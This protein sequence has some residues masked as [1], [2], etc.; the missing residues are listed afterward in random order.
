MEEP[1]EIILHGR[2]LCEQITSYKLLEDLSWSVS[3]K[4]WVLKFALSGDFQGTDR[5]PVETLWYALISKNY[6]YGSLCIFPATQGGII[7]TFPHMNIN[8]DTGKLWRSGDICI[9]TQ[10]GTW[11]STYFNK[12][13]FDAYRLQWCIKR[14][15]LWI[16]A[17]AERRLQVAGDPFEFPH[18]P[19]ESKI[20]T[21]WIFSED[22]EMFQ[23]WQVSGNKG[24]LEFYK[25]EFN[26]NL[27]VVLNYSH[28]NG[29]AVRYEWGNLLSDSKNGTEV[30]LWFRV[31]DIPV[32]E[33]WQIPLTWGELFELCEK[34]GWALREFLFDKLVKG[35]LLDKTKYLAIGF[36]VAPF[37]GQE[38]ERMHWF[39]VRLPG[40]HKSMT[41]FRKNTD[42][43]RKAQ[44]SRIYAK[45]Q[46]IK[47]LHS[48]NWMKDQITA[49]GLA[50]RQLTDFK[51]CIIGAGS[52]GS[53]L[54]D[55]LARMGCG[56][57]TIV[58]DDGAQVG[59]FSRH[60]LDMKSLTYYKAQ[61]VARRA[62]NTFPFIKADFCIQTIEKV[63]E[64]EPKF[65]D[66]FDL[67]IDCTAEDSVLSILSEHC[68]TE[69]Q[70]VF[71][72]SLGIEARSLLALMMRS[73]MQELFSEFK[74][75]T[76]A[77]SEEQKQKFP[78]PQ[79]PLEGIGCWHPIFPARIDDIQGLVACTIRQLEI[80]LSEAVQ[81]KLI[82]IERDDSGGVSIKTLL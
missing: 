35:R 21:S 22:P 34:K 71:S 8:R 24:L 56:R 54:T 2:R 77:W 33:P 13:P 65:L 51:I 11:K 23:N 43:W 45:H 17:A 68:T 15:L 31:S 25:P 53:Y 19:K 52:V 30:A 79:F 66:Q 60:T 12:E 6:P 78:N 76:K 36:P 41:G 38:P 9:K 28:D 55:L 32:I 61:E 63:L 14:S 50:N 70:I 42:E 4:K 58:D 16:K 64:R 67:I 73:P 1:S 74:K 62:N 3:E 46:S 75:K 48:E 29:S 49:R 18:I 72:I 27:A 7:S 69:Q 37:I 5:V 57:L 80:F 26:A 44:F 10:Y 82:I 20:F 47:W 40:L 81:S 59:N 39:A